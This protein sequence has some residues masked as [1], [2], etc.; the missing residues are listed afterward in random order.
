MRHSR[1]SRHWYRVPLNYSQAA[2]AHHPLAPSSVRR[3]VGELAP[4]LSKE[5]T[6]GGCSK[7]SAGTG[8][9]RLAAFSSDHFR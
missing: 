4:L 2:R 1:E 8:H 6:G 7:E 5:G 3:G 9:Q